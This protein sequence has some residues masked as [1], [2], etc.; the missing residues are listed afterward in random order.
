[1]LDQIKLKI[2]LKLLAIALGGGVFV[3]L[4]LIWFFH[5]RLIETTDNAYLKGD[6]VPI[7]SK[8]TAI[9]QEVLVEDGQPVEGGQILVK[10][11]SKDYQAKYDRAKAL[12]EEAIQQLE[13]TKQKEAIQE[14]EVNQ[15]Q[16]KLEAAKAES[17]RAEKALDRSNTLTK[18][19]F[20][21][22]SNLDTAK[23]TF[24]QA[25]SQLEQA[26]SGKHQA[27]RNFKITQFERARLEATIQARNADVRLAEIELNDTVIK[28]PNKGIVGQQVVKKGQLVRQGSVLSN[29]VNTENLWVIANFKETQI[30][31]MQPGQKATFY[32]DGF[33]SETFEGKVSN[34]LPATG[35]EF[36]LLP[37]DN[38]TGNFT[39]IVQRVPVRL[40]IENP[41]KLRLVPGLSVYASVKRPF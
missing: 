28:S 21:S 27:E 22:Q 12:H 36:T 41:K 30:T 32:V 6:V 20:T 40:I 34:I 17:E 38:A 13:Q 18:D 16:S 29:V 11:D 10:L 39:R 1:M 15:A 19:K 9:V 24:A 3:T 26:E 4:I 31:Y 33:P 14:L 8:V 7:A 25:K 37:A 5:W 35:S 2:P 23:A